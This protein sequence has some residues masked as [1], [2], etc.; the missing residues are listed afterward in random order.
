MK[1]KI[2]IEKLTDQLNG[3]EVDSEFEVFQEKIVVE[4]KLKNGETVEEEI[5]PSEVS[6]ISLRL[7]DGVVGAIFRWGAVDPRS[8]DQSYFEWGEWKVRNKIEK[9]GLDKL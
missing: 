2:D 9:L 1:D 3:D 8:Y 4:Y 7:P 5:H 6:L